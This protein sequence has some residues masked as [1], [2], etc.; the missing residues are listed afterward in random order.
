MFEDVVV[1][2]LSSGT[3]KIKHKTY[4]HNLTVEGGKAN[5]SKEVHKSSS[6]STDLSISQNASKGNVL[7]V[8]IKRNRRRKWDNVKQL[9]T[10]H[11]YC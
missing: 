1:R 11:F 8:K 6:L 2:Y 4:I 10:T 9:T 7:Y 3:P 5:V